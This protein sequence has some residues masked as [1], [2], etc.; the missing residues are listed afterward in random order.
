[1]KNNITLTLAIIALISSLISFVEPVH[2]SIFHDNTQVKAYNDIN[3]GDSVLYFKEPNLKITEIE[4]ITGKGSVYRVIE[5]YPLADD[6]KADIV[7]FK[8]GQ[9]LVNLSSISTLMP[10][11]I[12]ISDTEIPPMRE[13]ITSVSPQK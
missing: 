2:A 1:M 3:D 9:P 4:R 6:T 7:I 11:K 13:I 12:A 8:G 5:N 10:G